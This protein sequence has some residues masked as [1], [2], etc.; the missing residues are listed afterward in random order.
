[1]NIL[2]KITWRSMLQN[3]TR[4]LVTVI[5]VVLSAAMFTAVVTLGISLWDFL[6]RGQVHNQGD[7]FIQYDYLT[8]EQ[9]SALSDDPQITAIADLLVT[10]VLNLGEE[11]LLI[12][13]GDQQFYDTMP[14][15]LLEGRLPKNSG[16]ILLPKASLGLMEHDGLETEIGKTVSLKLDTAVQTQNQELLPE[17]T[18]QS[19]TASFTIVGYVDGNMYNDYD[20]FLEHALTF[21]DGQ[22]GSGL[23]HRLF[24]KT[25][26]RNVM[27]L[28]ARDDG[29]KKSI[30]DTLCGLYGVTRYNNVNQVLL[31]VVTV[32]CAI[33]MV[34]SVS[35]IYNA[36]SI[37]VSERTKQFGLLSSIGA[38]KKQMRR[39][40]Y[41]EALTLSV[42]GI[43][44]GTIAGYW[45]IWITLKL[46][47]PS[48][49]RSLSMAGGAVSLR[50]ILSPLGVLIAALVALVTMLISA[51]VPAVR[52]T[53][54]S[55]VEA[56]RQHK[57]YRQPRKVKQ[58]GKGALRLFGLPAALGQA[59]YTV[60]RGKYRTT[61]ISLIISFV[62]FVSAFCFNSSMQNTVQS[63]MSVQSFDISIRADM[64][65]MAQLRKQPFVS[66]AAY[67]SQQYYKAYTPD[68]QLSDKFLEYWDELSQYY[69][70]QTRNLTHVR[71]FYLE[72]AILKEYLIGQNID[73]D[74]YFD[75]LCPLALVCEKNVAFYKIQDGKSLRYVYQYPQFS[76]NT[77]RLQLFHEEL[78]EDLFNLLGVPDYSAEYVSC[79]YDCGPSGELLMVLLDHRIAATQTY[80]NELTYQLLLDTSESGKTSVSFY[81]YDPISGRA[82]LPVVTQ[83]YD[84]PQFYLGETIGELPYGIPTGASEQY[85]ETS[86][87]LP[88][89]LASGDADT[90]LHITVSDYPAALE[91]MNSHFE[92]SEFLDIRSG[93]E[94]NRTLLLVINVFAYGFIALISLISVANVFNTISTN[95]ALRRRD[96]GILRSIGFR[97]KDIMTM[98]QF[99]CLNYGLRALLWSIPL[100]FPISYLIWQI[101]TG[102]YS[103]SYQIP[104]LAMLIGAF[105]I[106]CVVFAAMF[107]SV[108]KVKKD[109]P[110]EAIRMDNL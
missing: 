6:V 35:L 33:I 59:Y 62:L 70:G 83:T 76:E 1:M 67:E 20:L 21:A 5:G 26:P 88:L 13:A 78:P 81:P 18:L 84:V 97:D 8:E 14:S 92:A 24:V 16:E 107:Y 11:E 4:T 80:E 15:Y 105:G 41:T 48:I 32:L 93:E 50:A 101:D 98:M 87:I 22:Q 74:P 10:G 19:Y 68:E 55:P 108:S 53:A 36:F 94:Y 27:Q 57:D 25:A 30:H 42:L 46:L 56:V 106:F 103:A 102:T 2:T 52:A 109:N 3:R 40:V 54:I 29:M 71:L 51:T 47:A 23:W 39:C 100:S 28:Y 31:A 73:P 79:T 58:L 45:G 82:E 75:P 77:Q 60:S 72:D 104:W 37:S 110:I 12:A 49:N 86:L 99:E 69:L 34:G 90:I 95:V 9:A 7:Y 91:Y 66:K 85:F 61:V 43:P 89:S 38:T 64:E 96:F 44:L 63:N 17:Q 65:E